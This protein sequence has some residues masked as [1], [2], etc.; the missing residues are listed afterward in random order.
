MTKRLSFLLSLLFHLILFF[1]FLYENE[2]NNFSGQGNVYEKVIEFELV[3]KKDV[4]QNKEDF[5]VNKNEVKKSN[6]CDNF[7]YGIGVSVVLLFKEEEMVK[8]VVTVYRNYPAYRA[9]IKP[10]DVIIKSNHPL[11]GDKIEKLELVINRNGELLTL[12]LFRDKIC[13]DG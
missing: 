5:V 3:D 1:P 13:I 12:I 4:L 2:E 7:Y 8:E 11:R 6:S 9:G 10:G